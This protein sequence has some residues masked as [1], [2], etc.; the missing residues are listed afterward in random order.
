[1]PSLLRSQRLFPYA[2]YALVIGILETIAVSNAAPY[3]AQSDVDIDTY[4]GTKSSLMAGNGLAF[5][6]AGEQW[7]VD[8]RLIVALAGQEQNF[9]KALGKGL[10]PVSSFNAWSWLSHGACI[11]FPSF[12]AGIQT[13]T[14][15]MRKSYISRGYRSISAIGS[16]YCDAATDPVG[17][18]AW[19][20]GVTTF[21]VAQ[22]GDV[23]DTT[24]PRITIHHLGSS[25][26]VNLN[27]VSTSWGDSG[28]F[29]L[30]PNNSANCAFLSFLPCTVALPITKLTHS[31]SYTLSMHVLP[32]VNFSYDLQ[33]NDDFLYFSVVA[34]GGASATLIS[35]QEA[36]GTLIN[37]GFGGSSAGV[38]F[39]LLAF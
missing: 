37:L 18:G 38:T 10:C 1:M 29:T 3:D 30:G 17:C 35:T 7:N 13:V 24:I 6:S 8:P 26:M 12:A 11:N 16:R 39:D 23:A 33:L 14:K 28:S 22:G 5:R 36:T 2:F 19:A 4:L 27:I 15:F 9:G 25:P 21:Y 34:P 32:T 20:H 31:G